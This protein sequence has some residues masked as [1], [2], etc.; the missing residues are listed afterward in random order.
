MAGW[1]IIS[2]TR[3]YYP[4]HIGVL[5]RTR[6]TET[7]KYPEERKSIDTPLVVAANADQPSLEERVEWSGKASDMGDSPVHEVPRDVSSRAGH[8]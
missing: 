4:E 8:V 5:E 1:S 2:I 6:G 7:S 3:Y